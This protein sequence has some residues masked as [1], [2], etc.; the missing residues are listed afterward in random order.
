MYALPNEVNVCDI[1]VCHE[2]VSIISYF[3]LFYYDK[4]TIECNEK[5]H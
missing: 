3:V 1:N 2:L 5:V 4:G